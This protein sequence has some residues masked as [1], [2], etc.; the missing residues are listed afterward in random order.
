LII[1]DFIFCFRHPNRAPN[2][3]GETKIGERITL[4]QFCQPVGKWSQ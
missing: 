1:K 3:V 4:M 2:N